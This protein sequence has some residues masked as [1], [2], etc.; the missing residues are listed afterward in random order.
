MY[1]MNGN[2][3]FQELEQGF[4]H[5]LVSAKEEE[6]TRADE[7][8][9]RDGLCEGFRDDGAKELL[10]LFLFLFLVIHIHH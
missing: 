4:Y 1:N 10:F 8:H 5:T 7:L 6:E 2:L 3:E 9:R